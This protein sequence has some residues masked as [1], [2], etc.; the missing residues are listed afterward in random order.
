M[1]FGII[2][3]LLAWV[4]QRL[5]SLNM[6]T[7]YASVASCSA[8]TALACIL[9][10]D[11]SFCS[12]S[13]TAQKNGLFRINS[14]VDFWNLLISWSAFV[15]GQNLCIFVFFL[16]CIL[17]SFLGTFLDSSCGG[18][19]PSLTTILSMVCFVLAIFCD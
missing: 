10:H 1:S 17:S 3:T 18:L 19:F 13:F 6:C 15:P 8:I 12:I 7:K 5:L 2:V 16:S 9:N 11:L 14:S 4:A